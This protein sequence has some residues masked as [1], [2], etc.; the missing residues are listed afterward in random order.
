[1]KGYTAHRVFFVV[2]AFVSF[3]IFTNIYLFDCARS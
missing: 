3:M 2:A 1:M